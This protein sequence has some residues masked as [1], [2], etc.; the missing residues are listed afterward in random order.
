MNKSLQHKDNGTL[1]RL[2][3]MVQICRI[4]IENGDGLTYYTHPGLFICRHCQARGT[5]IDSMPHADDC[6]I[7]EVK[8]IIE[9]IDGGGQ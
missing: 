2:V 8:R 6:P 3:R 9:S 4:M 5:G 7:T 1:G